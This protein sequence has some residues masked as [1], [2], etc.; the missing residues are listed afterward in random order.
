MLA[1]AADLGADR[2]IFGMPPP[3]SSTPSQ[4]CGAL[5]IQP[6]KLYDPVGEPCIFR[7]RLQAGVGALD[8]SWRLDARQLVNQRGHKE[9]GDLGVVLGGEYVPPNGETAIRA[10]LVS[11]YHAGV[12]RGFGH[13]FLV[14]RI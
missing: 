8:N 13:L 4:V 14:R 3:A 7:L 2:E 5:L 12:R 11:H 1:N 10:V 9:R 6:K